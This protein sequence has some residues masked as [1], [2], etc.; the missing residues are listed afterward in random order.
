MA[1][2]GNHYIGV[3]VGGTKIL[4]GVFN[5]S[6]K[7]LQTLKLSTKAER[8]VETV[9]D[10]IDR[11][12]RDAVDEADLSLNQIRAVGLGAPGTV[13]PASGRVIYA[14]NIGWQNVPLQKDLE[15]RLGLP[16]FIENDCKASTL[17][18]YHLELEPKP[19]SMVGI[20]LGTGVGGGLILNGELHAGANCAAGEVG[21]MI[22][23]CDGAKAGRAA[24]GCFEALAS[25]TAIFHQI[26]SAVKDGQKTCL[27]EMFKGGDL[28]EMR[29]GDL[30]RALRR[31]DKLVEKV[32]AEAANHTGIAVANLI[33]IL[34]PE[35]IVLGGGVIEALG[36]KMLPAIQKRAEELVLPGAFDGVQILVSRLGDHAGISGAAVLAQRR[37]K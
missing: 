13:D 8:G 21:H 5:S 24:R 31:G 25:R 30:R 1:R 2:E 11:A 14:I 32:V 12:I 15:K 7:L 29:S 16:V 19:D 6:L 20:F 28:Q 34:G 9:I 35:V 26:Q 3:D 22:L 10:R 33:H 36:E 23:G 4:V 37:S 18:I 27:T 17:G